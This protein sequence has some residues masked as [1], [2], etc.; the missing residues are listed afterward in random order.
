M[1]FPAPCIY[2]SILC[3]GLCR[4]CQSS[5]KSIFMAYTE[6]RVGV[7]CSVY[8]MLHTDAKCYIIMCKL[9]ELA[10]CLCWELIDPWN[11]SV[12]VVFGN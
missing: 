10:I 11:V 9:V 6:Q 3:A 12:A 5:Y 1:F 4:P 2:Y 7:S 8:D